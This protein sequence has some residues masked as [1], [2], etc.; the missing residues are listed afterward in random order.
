MGEQEGIASHA[1]GGECGLG[2]RVAPTYDNNIIFINSL[3]DVKLA[4]PT[5]V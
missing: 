3:H 2:A 4:Q 1:R 5:G